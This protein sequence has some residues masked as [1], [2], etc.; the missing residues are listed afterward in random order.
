VKTFA[1]SLPD[2]LAAFVDSAVA[3]GTWPSA[4]RLFIHAVT[5][6]RTEAMLGRTPEPEPEFKT[7]SGTIKAVDLTRQNF[8][9]AA[10]VA[11]LVDKIQTKKL[12][13]PPQ[14]GS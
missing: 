2:D 3:A 11:G 5:L 8:D 4:E 9:S 10:F 12:T 13:Q 7:K 14:G 1:V 6:A